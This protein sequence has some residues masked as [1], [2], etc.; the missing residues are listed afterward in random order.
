MTRGSVDP[1]AMR[2]V[3]SLCESAG[4]TVLSVERSG[5]GHYK[6]L[7]VAPDGRRTSACISSTPSERRNL[8]NTRAWLRRFALNRS[9]G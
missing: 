9:P 5:S 2:R 4:V 7:L 8:A 3:R 1:Q 6:A